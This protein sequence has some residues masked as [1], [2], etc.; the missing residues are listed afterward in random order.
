MAPIHDRMPV[1]LEPQVW[2]LWLDRDVGELEALKPLLVPYDEKKME[3]YAVSTLVN[4]PANDS[5]ACIH[6][7]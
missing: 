4:S 7:V 6:L 2:S 3:A 5:Q 1:I